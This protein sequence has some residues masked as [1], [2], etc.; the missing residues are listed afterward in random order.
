[1]SRTYTNDAATSYL[2]E[3]HY[4]DGLGRPVQSIQ[5][6]VTPAKADLATWQEYDNYGQKSRSWLPAIATGNNGAY[7]APTAFTAKSTAT[8]N[9]SILNN[10]AD[11][12]PYSE[13]TYERSPLN[14]VHTHFNPGEFW[15]DDDLSIATNY[16]LNK[17][18]T[19][20]SACIKFKVT[21]TGINTK[22]ERSGYYSDG[23]L[24]L[25]SKRDENGN[26]S[27]EFKNKLGQVV[28]SRQDNNGQYHDTYFVYDLFGN[29]CYVL[30]PLAADNLTDLT[31]TGNMI[32]NYAYIYKYNKY[33]NCISKKLPGC[34]PIYYVYD[35]TGS[36]IFSQ[37]GEQRAKASPEW[38]F[39]IP[40]AL[41]RVVLTGISKNTLNY[42]ADPLGSIVV[43]T[44]WAKTN[45]IYKGYNTPTGVA[46]T[47]PTLLSVSYYDNYEFL[48][49]NG[50]PNT[51]DT[52]YLSETGYGICYGD[53]LAANVIKNKGLVTGIWNAQLD[54]PSSFIYSVM[55]Y[56]HKGRII[57]T[58]SNNH[59]TGG[60]DK[61]YT[62]Y[63]FTGNPT[64]VKNIHSATGKPTQTQ[65]YTY[66]YDHAQRLTQAKH[67]LNSGGEVILA[68]NTYDELG[69]LKTSM[70][71]SQAN[72]KT[73]YGYNI[74][75]WT[76]SISSPLFSQTL[77]YT[78][79]YGGSYEQ[80]N[81]NISAMTWTMQGE[82]SSRGYTFTYDGL[83]R[84]TRAD[85]LVNGAAN[86]NYKTS[87]TYDKHGN[88]TALQRYGKT[89][90]SAYGIID[91]LAV[92]YTGNQLLKVTDTGS[93]VTIAES[94]DFKDYTNVATE[95]TYNKNGAMNKD[96]NKGITGIIYNSLNLPQELAIKNTSAVGKTYYTY[97]S[98][99]KKLRTVHKMTS[100][101]AYTPVLGSTSGDANYNTTKTT[102][103]VGNIIYENGNVKRILVD[104]GYIEGTT[105]YF[106]LSD[107]LGNNRIVANSSGTVIQK[108]HFYPFG[109][110]FA[111]GTKA[112]QGKQP[113]KF[114]DKELDDTHGLNLYDYS[115]RYYESALGRFTTM[116]P[117]A[118]KYY[119]WSPYHMAGNNSILNIDPFGMDYWSTNDPYQI[120][121]FINSLQQNDQNFDFSSWNHMTDDEFTSQL[122]YNDETGKG[123]L[124]YGYVENGEA[125][126][127]VK[128]FDAN[129]G[130]KTQDLYSFSGKQVYKPRSNALDY[131]SYYLL[132]IGAEYDDGSITWNVNTSGYVTGIRPTMGYP[133]NVGKGGR[134]NMGRIKGN[135][136]GNNQVQNKQ[137]RD[138]VN[139]HKLTKDQQRQLHDMISGEGLGFHEIEEVII[140]FIK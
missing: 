2:D 118:E 106:Y 133:P 68:A 107:H 121:Q 47:L 9:S 125:V 73:T 109:M 108:N 26:Y 56:D 92:T 49:L 78:E 135:M 87:Y 96:L 101:L 24:Y 95:Y 29:L 22:L 61:E 115:A 51:A 60:L 63:N 140:N 21:G 3:I 40:D 103:Y 84:L 39:S 16:Y 43:Y 27:Y 8:Y 82:T 134:S 64:S 77:Y 127:S 112:E 88:I 120:A 5:K 76:K 128:V 57:Q 48:G 111:E 1:M 70:A 72:L 126:V 45:N 69:R 20:Y 65:V 105:Y 42:T 6:G 36:L 90:A 116:D 66:N 55:Y 100:N 15:Y 138:L 33:G 130:S 25:T 110:A 93:N 80:N 102:D 10:V 75:S 35:K 119:S 50:I 7:I 85:Y 23:M 94:A 46:L 139:K 28:L 4:F 53:H 44:T 136:P 30:P 38:T 71:N 89:T 122:S 12:K 41:G 11:S 31:D 52:Q 67:K 123:Y 79:Q 81:G 74:R 124:S 113:Y 58:K 97:S 19:G 98:G 131:I 37:D 59:L 132:G 104:G 99:G 86:N 117:L 114:G 137:V 13:T 32:K 62:A 129:F 18:T 83:S 91:N 54:V 14:R 17:G 34:E